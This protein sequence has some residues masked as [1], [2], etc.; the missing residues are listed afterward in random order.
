MNPYS[1]LSRLPFFL[2]MSS[3]E[4]DDVIARVRLGFSKVAMGECIVV[5]G[6]PVEGFVFV[7][8]GG[9]ETVAYSDDHGFSIEEQMPLPTVLQPERLFGLTQRY[10]MTFRAT[11]DCQLLTIAKPEVMKLMTNS[12]V[13]R[14][15]VLN[16]LSTQTQRMQHQPW[17]KKAEGIRRKIAVFVADHSQ[18]PAGRKVLNI[19]MVRLGHEISESRLNVSRELNRMHAEGLIELKRERIL[20][21]HLEQLL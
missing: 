2:G 7:L 11:D 12:E 15:N 9:V 16:I 10:S 13:F 18:R 20:I 19:D 8:N 6:E 14:L 21:P 1:L 5:E 4:F 17:R 3:S